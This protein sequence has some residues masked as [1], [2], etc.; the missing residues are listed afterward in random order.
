MI[1]NCCLAISFYCGFL[2]ALTHQFID[3]YRLGKKYLLLKRNSLYYFT[4]TTISGLVLY[5]NFLNAEKE[6]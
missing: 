6:N 5:Y 3:Y 1:F 4:G 2:G